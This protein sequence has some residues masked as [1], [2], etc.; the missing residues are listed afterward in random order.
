MKGSTQSG[1][2]GGLFRKILTIIQFTISGVMI[3]STL[4]IINQL[5]FLQNKDQGWDMEDIITLRLPDNNPQTKMEL[6]K[7]KLLENPVIE[8]AGLTNTAVGNGSGKVIF[9][10]ETSEGMDQRGI[11]FAVVDHDFIETMGIK[12]VEGRDFSTDLATDSGKMLIN[13]TGV[14]ELGLIQPV[15]K[16]ITDSKGDKYEIIGVVS[17]FN[18]GSLHEKIPP[19]VITIRP[20]ESMVGQRGF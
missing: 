9:Q 20:N 11:N 13:E 7:E 10:M 15:G 19:T 1:K 17:D 2:S 12:M 14:A 5:N 8:K 3:A 16:V 18:I 6:L 4:V